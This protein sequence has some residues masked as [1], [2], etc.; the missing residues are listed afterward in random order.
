MEETGT[1]KSPS[2]KSLLHAFQIAVVDDR[3]VM[4]D[5]WNDSV[6]KECFIGVKEDQ[7]KLLVKSEDEYTSTIAKIFKV[8]SEYIILTENSLYVVS[9]EIPTRRVS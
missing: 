7:E 8:E 4:F 5:Y 1:K 3:P 6:N 9:A 2:A